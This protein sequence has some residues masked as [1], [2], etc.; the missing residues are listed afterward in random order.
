MSFFEFPHDR[1]YEGDLGYIIKIIE[2]L[3]NAYNKFFDINKITYHDPIN[4]NISESYP[5]N[6]IVYDE[7]SETLYISRDAVPAGVNISNSDYWRV[8]SPFKIDTTLSTGSIN[9]VANKTITNA[10]NSTNSA[11]NSTVSRLNDEIET[12]TTQNSELVSSL[13]TL[14]GDLS[15][16]IEARE[17][18]DDVINARIDEI[19][20]LPEG[21]TSGDAELADIR[22][23]ANGITYPNAGDAVRGQYT[24][25]DNK[26]SALG[27]FTDDFLD[28]TAKYNISINR[29][30]GDYTPGYYVN[31]T[32]GTLSSSATY[33]ASDFVKIDNPSN[34]IVVTTYGTQDGRLR[35]AFYSTN[36][37][38]D[39]VSGGV[40]GEDNHSD[41]YNYYYS[42]ID[43][44]ATA[45]YI[46]FSHT[47]GTF[48]NQTIGK[49]MVSLGATLHPFTPFYD[50]EWNIISTEERGQVFNSAIGYSPAYNHTATLASGNYLKIANNNSIKVN[51]N[52]H[53][54]MNIDN[55]F[56]TVLFGHGESTYSYYFKVDN[57]YI[58]IYSGG[59]EGSSFEHGLTL[60]TYLDI[61]FSTNEH[62]QG[63][64]V[65]NTRTGTF[66]HSIS[67]PQGYKGE[68]FIKPVNC[69]ITDVSIIF[70][71]PD[72]KKPIWLF[73][74]SYV[75]FTSPDR[76]PYWLIEWGFDNCM[77]NGFPGMNSYE[78]LTDLENYI[79]AGY[80]CPKYII[81]GLGMNDYDIGS[82]VRERWQ[83]AVETVM[84]ICKRFNITL[85][86]A[87]I[88]NTPDYTNYYKNQYVIDSGYRYIDFAKAVGATAINSSW[89]TGALSEDEVHPTEI[90]ARML[91]TQLLIDMPEMLND[92]T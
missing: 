36:N 77:I 16:E 70:A 7:L 48:A 34:K 50:D 75:T 42:I 37:E 49:V 20:T 91:A 33:G 17:H 10:L 40:I 79:K 15:D 18:A 66:S 61:I 39:F 78:A 88:P 52:Y 13:E 29:Y 24:E 74:D 38:S 86:L 21:S 90:G 5:A 25:L 84:E 8:V 2:E 9:P 72:L 53:F 27:D 83:D 64:I 68:I 65:L 80:G 12:R 19:T 60:D 41:I 58:T 30:N 81:W 11:L 35:Y 69:S 14:S 45:K 47:V 3:I 43:I 73:G 31:N 22:V 62:A 63:T 92:N 46:R 76:Y 57:T 4:W 26:I 89:Y 28:D 87:T 32:N 55:S 85:I 6:T 59:V 51:K 71:S 44:P 82:S 54:K 56:D 1:T 23:G 67:V